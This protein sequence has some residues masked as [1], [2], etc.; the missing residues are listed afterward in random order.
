M[1]PAIHFLKEILTMRFLAVVF[2]LTSL[3]LTVAQPTI[4]STVPINGAMGVSPG[5]AVMF[6]FSTNMDT[7]A[8]SAHFLDGTVGENPTVYS[9]WSAGNTVLT[10]TP[11]PVFANNHD[12]Q[13]TVDGQDTSGNI[14]TGTTAGDFTTVMGVNG[15]S[16]T[17]ANTGFTVGKYAVYGQTNSAPP[18]FLIYEFFAQTIL[19][20]NRTATNITVTIP[21]SAGVSNLVEDGLR[22]EQ[23]A[24]AVYNPN[25]TNLNTIFPSGNYVFNVS[26]TASNQQVTVNLPSTAPPNAPQAINYT[27]AQA[28]DPSQPFTL[29]WNTF[30]NGGSADWILFF[31]TDRSGLTIFQTPDFGQSGALNGT[32]TSFTIPAGTL[33]A[34]STNLAD[35][36]FYHPTVTASGATTT[37]A[38]VASVT[39]FNIITTANSAAAPILTNAVWSGGI[40][41]FNI[42]TSPSQTVTVIYNTNLN[43]AL[44]SWPVLLTTNNTGS[45]DHISDPHSVTNKTLFYR[46]RNGS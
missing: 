31:I 28:I 25:L 11:S 18:P 32:A 43:S 27:A 20:S 4:I 24:M 6:T 42:L 33:P 34:S 39:S 21:I 7:T 41:G 26:A 15:G 37:E 10:C 19:S 22:P 5:A 12:I 38:F 14:L 36:V 16:G 46:A 9:V 29:T 8:T 1:N 3:N 45:V 40:F 44:S 13:W 17:N 2:F 23:Y 35:V 30:T